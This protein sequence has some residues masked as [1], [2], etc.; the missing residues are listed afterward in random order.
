MTMTSCIWF[1]QMDLKQKSFEKRIKNSSRVW[2]PIVRFREIRY[3]WKFKTFSILFFLMLKGIKKQISQFRLDQNRQRYKLDKNKRNESS[4]N[5]NAFKNVVIPSSAT[6]LMKCSLSSHSLF[7][8]SIPIS[9]WLRVDCIYPMV[10]IKS[11]IV[12]W[13]YR[14]LSFR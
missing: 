3:N 8:F 14:L 4:Y 10:C 7:I 13:I 11:R 5:L 1:A 6:Q 12:T 9:I 2:H